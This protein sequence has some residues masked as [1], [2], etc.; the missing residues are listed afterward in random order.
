ML[1]SL[2]RFIRVTEHNDSFKLFGD[3]RYFNFDNFNFIAFTD[4]KTEC[5]KLVVRVHMKG[6]TDFFAL[7]NDWDELF[8]VS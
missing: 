8:E 4:R 7:Q 5:G 3:Y 6:G 2:I 1:N